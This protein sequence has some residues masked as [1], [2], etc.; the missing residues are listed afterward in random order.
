MTKKIKEIEK[1][2]QE[3]TE[4][5]KAI[6]ESRTVADWIQ[7]LS[8][9]EKLRPQFEALAANV[10]A[11]LLSANI[12]AANIRTVDGRTA[13]ANVELY[14]GELTNNINNTLQ[15]KMMFNACVSAKWS[16]F[17][18]AVAAIVACISVILTMCLK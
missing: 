13:V 5:L 9:L 4:L 16:C 11:P 1:Y 6:N 3:L 14:I 10:G 18:A 2:E 15:T 7:R 17:F 12:L 8:D